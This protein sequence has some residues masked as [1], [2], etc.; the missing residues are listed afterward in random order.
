[1]STLKTIERQPIEDLLGMS[2]G[3]VLDFTDA[4]FASFFAESVGRDIHSSRYTKYGTSKAKKLRAFWDIE[5]D[6]LVGK[7]ID[8]N[9]RAMGV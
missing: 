2:G 6:Q 7:N 9:D 3:Y 4:T 8:R 5:S 1:M